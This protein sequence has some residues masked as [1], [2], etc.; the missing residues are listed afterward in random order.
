MADLLIIYIVSIF[1]F[2][3]FAWDKHL[4]IYEKS[5]V[6]ESILMIFAGIGGA[7]GALC[8]MILYKHKILKPMFN[9]GVPVLLCVQLTIIVLYRVF[10]L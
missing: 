5:R 6:P 3:L 4:A 8:G 1:T 7:F 10:V 9:I 2:M